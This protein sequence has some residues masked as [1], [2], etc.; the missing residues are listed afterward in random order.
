MDELDGGGS[1]E[2][3]EKRKN[4]TER[5]KRKDLTGRRMKTTGNSL[6]LQLHLLEC[7]QR[8]KQDCLHVQSPHEKSC[9]K[10]VPSLVFFSERIT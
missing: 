8:I 6:S 9:E 2:K 3:R 4:L 5:K 7:S 1:R 10:E